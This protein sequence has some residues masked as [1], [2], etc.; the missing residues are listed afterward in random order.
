MY[1]LE[2][3]SAAVT[4]RTQGETRRHRRILQTEN[5]IITNEDTDTHTGTQG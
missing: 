1:I 3:V 2:Y 4:I 5:V